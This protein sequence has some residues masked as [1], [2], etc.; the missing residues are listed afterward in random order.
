M[1]EAEK[2]ERLLLLLRSVARLTGQDGAPTPLAREARELYPA[3]S[4]GK[5]W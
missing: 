2:L 1:S 5:G 3:Y 4:G